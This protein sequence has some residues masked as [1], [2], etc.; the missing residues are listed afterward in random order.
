MGNVVCLLL[1]GWSARLSFEIKTKSNKI[2]ATVAFEVECEC[3]RLELVLVTLG[4]EA[5]RKSVV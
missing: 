1:Y 4:Q 3:P 5:D 2:K